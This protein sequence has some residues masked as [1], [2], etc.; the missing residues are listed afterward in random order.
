MKI[1]DVP[2]AFCGFV[3]IVA[4][5]LRCTQH[6]FGEDCQESQSLHEQNRVQ[7]EVGDVRCHQSEGQHALHIVHKTTP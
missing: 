5:E 7:E 6:C 3:L 2:H 4:V 1:T